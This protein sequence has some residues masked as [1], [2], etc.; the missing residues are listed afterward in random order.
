MAH[1]PL[2]V[3]LVDPGST[4]QEINEPIG[5]AALTGWLELHLGVSVHVRQH[6]SQMDGSLSND[7]LR[8]ADVLGFATRLGSAAHL[9]ALNTRLASMKPGQRPRLV[10]GDLLATFAPQQVLDI[11]PDAIC[12]IGEGEEALVTLLQETLRTGECPRP[13][14]T[15]RL[16]DAGVPNLVMQLDGRIEHTPRRLV[17][18][19]GSPLPSRQHLE[20]LGSQGGIARC[21][22]SRGCAWGRCSFCAIQY[23]YCDQ[24]AWRPYPV[25]RV[26][27]DLETLSAQGI[28]SPYFTDED[29]VGNDPHRAIRLAQAIAQAKTNG[30]IHPDLSLYLD[31]RADSVLAPARKGAPSGHDVLRALQRAGLREV[32]IG[33]ESGAK[34][35][36][37]RYRKASTAQRNL[38]VLHM[39]RELG[40]QVDVGF[41]MFDPEMGLEELDLNLRFIHEAGLWDHDARLGKEIRLEAG[42]PLVEEYREKGLITGDL[43]LDELTYPYRWRDPRVEQIHHAFRAWEQERREALYLIQAATRGEVPSEQ[44]RLRRRGVLGQIRA[45]ENG[46]LESLVRATRAGDADWRQAL[47]HASRERDRLLELWQRSAAARMVA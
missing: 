7:D 27:T 31:L 12:V 13:R 28:R 17:D 20:R 30:R 22:A 18:L 16:V 39:L 42:T 2:H 24:A 26:V 33:I 35:Q 36:V 29:F 23:K 6:F 46:L 44:E 25:Q 40:L 34:E 43:E 8:W 47:K 14:L 37:R 32:F 1:S 9:A 38:K 4:R 19:D 21:E 3:L 10:L 11:A 5:V 41:I 15:R 45:V